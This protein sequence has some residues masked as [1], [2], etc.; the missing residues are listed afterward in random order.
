MATFATGTTRLS[1][2][3][4]SSQRA[5]RFAHGLGKIRHKLIR[6]FYLFENLN[7]H[8]YILGSGHHVRDD[9]SRDKLWG[10]VSRALRRLPV[11]L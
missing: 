3:D 8:L 11:G 6:L 5:T 9:G 1:G 4:Y 7:L 10:F 2:T